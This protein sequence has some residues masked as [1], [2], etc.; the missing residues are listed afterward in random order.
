MT[1][2]VSMPR[3]GES[4]VEGTVERWLVSEGDR[5]E[6]DQILC[7]VT[8]DKVDAEVPAPESGVVA[9]ILVAEGTTV[10][11]GEELI[12]LD[13]Q[14]EP[15]AAAASSPSTAAV[16]TAGSASREAAPAEVPAARGEAAEPRVS[17]LAR[18]IAE[19]QGV[20]LGGVAGTGP[21]GRVTRADVI[22]AAAAPPRPAA[23]PVAA[24]VGAAPAPGT[25]GEFLY[26]MKIP[27]A[28]L[29]EGD[30]EIPFSA[31]RRRVAEHMVVSKIV[32]PHVGTVAE[33]DLQRLVALRNKHK[34][35]FAA[36][37]GF[38]LTFLPFIIAATVRGLKRFPRMNATVGD[39]V[40][41]E[42]AG[43]HVGVA[44]ET[45]RGLVVPVIRNAANLSLVGL[46]QAIEDL[47][48][49]ARDRQ[50]SADDMQGGTFTVSNPGRQGNLYGFAVINQ[51]QVGILRMG[52]IRKRPVVV[53]RD[54]E[55]T[56]AIR[57]M[58]H[59]AL[60]YDHRIIDGVTGNSFLYAVAKELEAAEFEL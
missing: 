15:A 27:K 57:P 33:L 52:E 37:N 7:E 48:R 16:A 21:G 38:G 39:Q 4:V 43:I 13:P 49:R 26:Q 50:L 45:E 5:V 55:D 2:A 47:A 59:L 34:Q 12:Q 29:R 25:L 18:R 60:S 8:T 32:S 40:I 14:G 42:R 35:S 51:P 22:A 3:M 58:M 20:D 46:A 36:A 17:P 28:P 23:A 1:I 56:I 30:K 31:I 9:R 11:V 24:A 44:V 19:D 10:K 41:I 54:G 53:E 6:K